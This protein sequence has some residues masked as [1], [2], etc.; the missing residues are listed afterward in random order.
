MAVDRTSGERVELATVSHRRAERRSGSAVPHQQL[1]K[2]LPAGE[3]RVLDHG[4]L[5]IGVGSRGVRAVRQQPRRALRVLGNGIAQEIVESEPVRLGPLAGDAEPHGLRPEPVEPEGVVG[6]ERGVVERLAV[7]RIGAMVHQQPRERFGLRVRG[8]TALPAADHAREHGERGVAA[9]PARVRRRAAIQQ[10]PGDLYGVRR[11]PID[12][13][14]RVREAQQ[15]RPAI[16]PAGPLGRGRILVQRRAY[17]VHVARHDRGVDAVSGD[18]GMPRQQ[19]GRVVPARRVIGL[20]GV[21]LRRARCRQVADRRFSRNSRRRSAWLR[22][23]SSMSCL[24]AAQ[25]GK[26]SASSSWC[27]WRGATRP[28]SV[29]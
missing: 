20:V 19:T 28:T 17:G 7:D 24:S 14:P 4:L 1:H 25:L 29:C 2:I 10:E 16:G 6:T 9:Q 26:P 18:L 5:R 23:R 15:R 11:R 21:P 13:Q 27:V 3:Q 12:R 22:A 8:L